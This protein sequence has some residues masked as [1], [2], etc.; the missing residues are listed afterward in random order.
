MIVKN[1]STVIRRCL[2][3]AI[4]LIDYWVIVDTG[5]N[6]G[7]QKIVAETLQNIPGEL[8][9]RPWVNF[10]FN[11]NE[12]LKLA[13]N[14]AD[15]ILFIDADEEFIFSSDFQRFELVDDF[16][17]MEHQSKEILFQRISLINQDSRWT[18]KGVI[19]EAI[20]HP[21]IE[22]LKGS[23]IPGITIKHA[24]DGNRAQDSKKCLHDAQTIL[25]AL[26]TDPNNTRLVFY[27]AQS[28]FEAGEYT[29]ARKAYEKRVTMKNSSEEIFWSLYRIGMIQEYHQKLEADVYLY[30]YCQA[31][32]FR[33][34]RIEPLYYIACYY[35]RL[36]KFSINYLLLKIAWATPPSND[37][38]P[39]ESWLRDWGLAFQLLQSAYNIGRHDEAN[40]LA[41][42]LLMN[43]KLPPDYR[44]ALKTVFS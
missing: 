4:R 32:Q 25:E 21:A 37:L 22:R 6:D 43:P 38:I 1:E 33:P 31:F 11:R 24:M 20:F 16:Y 3:S 39:E 12:A 30:S 7:T 14:K 9:E 23:F 26:R 35:F 40:D 42:Q 19:H 44:N 13:Q 10:E 27:L 28:Y 29:L 8:H 36:E 41:H 15:Y 17:V 2:S 18:W 5:S 34:S